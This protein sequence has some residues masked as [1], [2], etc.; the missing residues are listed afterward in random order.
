MHRSVLIGAIL[1]AAA[2]GLVGFRFG[3]NTAHLSYPSGEGRLVKALETSPSSDVL[4]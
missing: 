2:D 3:E 1:A 4:S